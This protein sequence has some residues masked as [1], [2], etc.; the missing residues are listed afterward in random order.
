MKTD[1][2][3]HQVAFRSLRHLLTQDADVLTEG[4]RSLW[5]ELTEELRER[6]AP[7]LLRRASS[8]TGERSDSEG[9]RSNFE[10]ERSNSERD[11]GKIEGDRNNSLGD[12]RNAAGDVCTERVHRANV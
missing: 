10:G 2:N 11:C 9:E 3:H 6:D 4:D 8:K 1:D 5:Y 12:A 7:A